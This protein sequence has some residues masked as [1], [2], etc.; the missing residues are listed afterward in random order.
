M[1]TATA[2]ARSD[3]SRLAWKHFPLAEHRMVI[4][5]TLQ[6]KRN[7]IIKRIVNNLES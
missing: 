3:S 7:S 1:E 2:K 6:H 4:A 5:A